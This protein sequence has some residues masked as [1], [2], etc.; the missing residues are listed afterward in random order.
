MKTN[1][2]D[3]IWIE[4]FDTE[5]DLKYHHR[6]RTIYAGRTSEIPEKL[7]EECAELLSPNHP[8]SLWRN[9]K[10]DKPQPV[11][12]ARA[13]AKQSIQSACDKPYC[14]IYKTK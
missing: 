1:L 5:S 11:S 4:G 2:K 12:I 14:V 13:T 10:Y 9:Y 7:I 8:I 6:R 3:N